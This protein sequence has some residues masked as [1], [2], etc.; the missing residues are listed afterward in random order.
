MI[1]Q[2]FLPIHGSLKAIS[3]SSLSRPVI[4]GNISQSL[5]TEALQSGAVWWHIHCS[6]PVLF[7]PIEPDILLH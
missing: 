7:F 5:V 2:F 1:E 6:A 3:D 4:N